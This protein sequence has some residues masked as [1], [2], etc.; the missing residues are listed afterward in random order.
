MSGSFHAARPMPLPD[1]SRLVHIGLPK[2]GTTALQ[3]ALWSAR[4]QLEELGAHNVSRERHERLVGLTAAGAVP[5]YW[6]PNDARWRELATEFR[7]YDARVTFWSSESLSIAAPERL[8]HLADRLGADTH[9]VVTL[10]TLANQLSSRWYQG[11]RRRA[12]LS[13]DEWLR[14]RFDEVGA[15]GVL[16]NPDVRG[17]VVLH[18][19][20][21]VRVL[22]EWGKVFGED[23]LIFVIGD[24]GDPTSHLRVFEGLLDLPAGLLRLPQS[25][26][27]SL[28][29]PEAELL[30]HFATAYT[31]RG[32]DHATWMATV[33][34]Q[35]EARLEEVAERA[36]QHPIQMPRWAAER[37][38]EY[39]AAW[40]R[41]L[42]ASGATVIGD[43]GHLLVDPA[44]YPDTVTPPTTVDVESAGRLMDEAFRVAL[45]Q[46]S[47]LA[48]QTPALAACSSNEILREIAARARRRVTR[49]G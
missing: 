20:N 27:K 8:G 4:D 18:R 15:D 44:D 46:G 22:R 2:T 26:N 40:T 21:P 16:K 24:P 48:P 49:R 38:N 29:Y 43:P 34:S 35:R 47:R 10:R 45:E 3:A 28:P 37:A 1:G 13:L 25:R 9:I 41:T 17:E 23:R 30:R 6:R 11:L 12:R 7:E 14:R 31:Q 36:R 5:S 42:E 33:G 39:A 19:N 32:G